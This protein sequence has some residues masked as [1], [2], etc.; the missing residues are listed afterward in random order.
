M[1]S[2]ITQGPRPTASPA[3]SAAVTLVLTFAPHP[4][5]QTRSCS[6]RLPMI[7]LLL[8]KC[9]PTLLR[10]HSCHYQTSTKFLWSVKRPCSGNR[11]GLCE[12]E[13][14]D[15]QGYL[16]RGTDFCQCTSPG[17]FSSAARQLHIRLREIM[18]QRAWLSV[19][20]HCTGE[21]KNKKEK[22]EK[23]EK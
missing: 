1:R 6:Q 19:D 10:K 22:K 16:N 8:L 20:A 15:C 13:T 17:P 11:S 5:T 18:S 4:H 3:P 9:S 2:A 21:K 14:R 23:Q 12:E 7:Q